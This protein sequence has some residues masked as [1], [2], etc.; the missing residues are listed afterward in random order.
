[1]GENL[2]FS[3]STSASL[4]IVNSKVV[5]LHAVEVH[6]GKEVWLLLIHDLGTR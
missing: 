5:P 4:T 3:L 6:E 1:M 2:N